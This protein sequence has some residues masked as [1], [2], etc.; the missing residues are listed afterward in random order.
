M[1]FDLAVWY[2]ELPLTDREAGEIYRKLCE[3]DSE[4]P[5]ISPTVGTFYEEL[6]REFHELDDVPEGDVDHCPWNCAIDKSERHV[7]MCI[8]WS[9]S[10][11]MASIVIS[12]ALQKRLV[13]FDP[14]ANKIQLP[15][16]LEPPKSRFRF[17]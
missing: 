11:E 13:C 4:P 8:A 9:R 17:W 3:G 6:V 16:A 1:S 2:S 15:S 7:L 14:Q 10:E 5:A 12:K